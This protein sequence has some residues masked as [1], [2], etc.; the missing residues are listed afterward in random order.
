MY[1]DLFG[2]KK[3]PW[4]KN[5]GSNNMSPDSA[6]SSVRKATFDKLPKG[7]DAM[8]VARPSEGAVTSMISHSSVLKDGKFKHQFAHDSINSAGEH[9]F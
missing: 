9:V 2:N 6:K 5:Q 7:V 3:K 8:N 1:A 4:I